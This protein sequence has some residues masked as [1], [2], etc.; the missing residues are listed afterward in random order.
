[1]PPPNR[2]INELAAT[3][4][5]ADGGFRVS[6]ELSRRLR[7][8]LRRQSLRPDSSNER[9]PLEGPSADPQRQAAVEAVARLLERKAQARAK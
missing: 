5:D 8:W 3:P 2:R 6:P 9:L 1:L 7:E 4:R